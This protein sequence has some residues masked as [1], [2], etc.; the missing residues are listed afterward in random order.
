MATEHTRGDSFMYSGVFP[1]LDRDKKQVSLLGWTGK[2]EAV[3]GSSAPINLNFSWIDASIGLFRL[4]VKNTTSWALGKYDF[5]IELTSL[6]GFVIS[7][8]IGSFT[9]VK[10]ITQNG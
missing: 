5:D 8:S 4:E 9:V 6:D 1:V 3:L 7:S 10:D 2:C